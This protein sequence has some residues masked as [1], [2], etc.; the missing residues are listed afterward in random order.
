L[1]NH[2]GLDLRLCIQC[3]LARNAGNQGLLLDGKGQRTT[4]QLS[5]VDKEAEPDPKL[6]VVKRAKERKTGSDR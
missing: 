1:F 3:Y 6:F 4:V 2:D 5:N